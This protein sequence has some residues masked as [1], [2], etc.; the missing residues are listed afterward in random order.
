MAGQTNRSARF[1]C[2]IAL[3]RNGE[4]IHTFRGTVE[5]LIAQEPGG[6]NGFGYDPLFYYP[7]FGCTFGEVSAD[8]K[9]AVSHRGKALANLMRYLQSGPRDP[10]ISSR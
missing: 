10:S 6:D 7:P 5:G 1:V 8:R 3:V 4:L 9:Q 2:V